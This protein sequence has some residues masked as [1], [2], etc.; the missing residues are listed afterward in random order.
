MLTGAPAPVIWLAWV[1]VSE[2]PR[3][4]MIAMPGMRSSR[5]AFTGAESAAP[6]LMSSTSDE[7]S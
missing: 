4:S 1:P 5:P 3:P 6:P 2:E 7:R